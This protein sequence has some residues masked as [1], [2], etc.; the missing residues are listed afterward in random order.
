M[1][2]S[3]VGLDSKNHSL[4]SVEERSCSSDCLA[5]T[6]EDRLHLSFQMCSE[7]QL[8]GVAHLPSSVS[9]REGQLNAIHSPRR[10][11]VVDLCFAKGEFYTS[12]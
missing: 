10:I 5:I 7:T 3:P 2:L 4:S 8:L 12:W 11:E 1:V 6:I 9:T